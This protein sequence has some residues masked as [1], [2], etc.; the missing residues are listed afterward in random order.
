MV[1]IEAVAAV[2]NDEA[3][4][5]YIVESIHYSPRSL[6]PSPHAVFQD[7]TLSPASPAA[8][9]LPLFSLRPP[10]LPLRL[11]HGLVIGTFACMAVQAQAQ[12]ASGTAVMN[13]APAQAVPAAY[14]A[15]AMPPATRRRGA[16]R[17]RVQADTPAPAPVTGA[18]D[19][20]TPSVTVTGSRPSN[21]I[22]RQSYDVRADAASTN[23]SAAD[24]LNKIPSVN[25]DPDGTLSLRGQTNVQVLVDGKPSAM[26]QGDSRA[27]TLSAMPADDIESIEVI[28][29]PGAQFGNEAGGGP[30]LNL[31]MRRNKRPGG[32]GSIIANEGVAGRRNAAVSGSYNSGY[33]GLQGSAYGRRDGRNSVGDAERERLDPATNAFL[34]SSQL[35]TSSGLTGAAGFNGAA[36]YNVGAKDTITGNLAYAHNDNSNFGQDR[37]INYGLDNVADSDYLRTTRRSG[38]TDKT[39]WGARYDHKGAAPGELFKLDLRVSRADVASD[40]NYDNTYTLRPPGVLD[41]RARQANRNS[42]RIADL[43]GDLEQPTEQ[44]LIKAGFKTATNKSNVDTQYT[45]I[46]PATLAESPNFFRSNRFAY[47]EDVAALYGSYQMRLGERWSALGGVRGEYTHIE[48]AQIT[49]NIDVKNHYFNA[50]PSAFLSYKVSDLTTL[51]FS[52]AHRIRRPNAGELNPF[53]VYRDEFNVSSGNPN[54]KPTATDSFEIGYET[55]FGNLDTNLR[56]YYRKD[57]DLIAERKVFLSDTVLLTTRD[58]SGTNH[59]GGLEFTVS[60]KLAKNLTLNAS[61]N[62]AYTEQVVTNVLTNVDTRRSAESLS[63]QGRLNWQVDDFDSIQLAVRGHGRQLTGQGYREPDWTTNLTFRRQ[64]TPALSAVLNINDVFNTSKISTITDNDILHETSVRRYDGRLFY[65]GLAYRFGGVTGNQEN[66]ER[67]GRGGRGGPG[68]R[69]PGGGGGGFGGGAGG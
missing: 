17:E 3:N 53:V 67:N 19:Q 55:R 9:V 46:D 14:P 51:R 44:G 60:G 6:F 54:L 1:K 34:R 29:N 68:M 33:F 65:V 11:L 56:G 5:L 62:L 32:F 61:G 20:A 16:N 40:N 42:N 10:A 2:R 45:N 59:A 15:A 18:T 47:E 26:L 24:A 50:I 27:A 41:T 52:Y 69:G 8:P 23:D 57:S 49:N 64:I 37:Y 38:A 28:N 48:L 63:G 25:V 43:T 31:V 36:S 58:N 66:R 21:Q 12:T 7:S 4:E 22:D 35:S 13:T 30:I 39:S